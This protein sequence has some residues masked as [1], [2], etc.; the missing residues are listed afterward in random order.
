MAGI[1]N[2]VKR[3]NFFVLGNKRP[4]YNYYIEKCFGDKEC[5]FG[6]LFRISYQG[7][8]ILIVFQTRMFTKLPS[9]LMFA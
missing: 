8:E 7:E 9:E 1:L 2:N 5:D 6:K 3:I 4:T